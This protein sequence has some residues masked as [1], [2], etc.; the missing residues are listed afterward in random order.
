MFMTMVDE[1][2]KLSQP[3]TAGQTPSPRAARGAAQSKTRTGGIAVGPS[4]EG[5]EPSDQLGDE[6]DIVPA[7]LLSSFDADLLRNQRKRDLPRAVSTSAVVAAPSGRGSGS[8]M[9]T[10][11]PAPAPEPIEHVEFPDDPTLFDAE[12]SDPE[13]EIIESVSIQSAPE[14]SRL[15]GDQTKPAVVIEIQDHAS[16]SSDGSSNQRI[17]SLDEL[18]VIELGDDDLEL[19]DDSRPSTMRRT[20]PFALFEDDLAS[21]SNLPPAQRENASLSHNQAALKRS[22]PAP[23]M[24]EVSEEFENKQTGL[25]DS[26]GA[27]QTPA[28]MY[29]VDSQGHRL[30][31]TF[32]EPVST[33]GRGRSNHIRLSNDLSV[34]RVHFVVNRLQGGTYVIADQSSINGTFLNG[35]KIAQSDLIHGDRIQIGASKLHFVHPTTNPTRERQM[36]RAARHTS[37]ESAS[38]FKRSNTFKTHASL[39]IVIFLCF[40]IYQFRISAPGHLD[41]DTGQTA[42]QAYMEGIA[43]TDD[44]QWDRAAERFNAAKQLNPNLTAITDHLRWIEDERKTEQNLTA[45]HA[46]VQEF[47]A[48]STNRWRQADI[49]RARAQLATISAKSAYHE[50]SRQLQ[51][52]IPKRENRSQAPS[53]KDTRAGSADSDSGSDTTSPSKTLAIS[54]Q[55]SIP[56]RDE[57]PPPQEEPTRNE[58][59]QEPRDE[60]WKIAQDS[61]SK[62]AARTSKSFR[63]GFAL[64]SDKKFEKAKKLFRS[65]SQRGAKNDRERARSTLAGVEKF[66][67]K[68]RA[69]R[70]AYA[71]RDWS[72]ASE[73][74]ERAFQLDRQVMGGTGAFAEELAPKIATAKGHVGMTFFDSGQYALS[75]KQMRQASKFRASI[76]TV[77]TL[78]RALDKKARELFDRAVKQGDENPSEAKKIC[79]IVM[80]MVS[81]KSELY[82]N[83]R[84]LERSL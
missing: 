13:I 53:V 6:T 83:A 52:T 42:M 49:E 12:Y 44:T 54:Q 59:S 77:G 33:C 63:E 2:E 31:F 62:K 76:P 23:D 3:G 68:Y 7:E 20:G 55:N 79:R 4:E 58:N 5:E 60:S 57:P 81:V 80:S 61:Q 26:D 51:L 50:E 8:A 46:A 71:L 16:V 24:P 21:T 70:K 78:R 38:L 40:D 73:D 67:M 47:G 72:T 28:K 18:S 41:A 48:G 65:L 11:T 15:S 25:A 34:G 32:S 39:L 27:R 37:T 84:T 69:G 19:V 75:F 10:P 36:T 74:L 22:A 66:H 45:I 30:E 9:Q 29:G 56:I 35:V 17:P 82:L 64:Y 14:T 1:K 43:A